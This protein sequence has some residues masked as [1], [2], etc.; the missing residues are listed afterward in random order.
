MIVSIDIETTGLNPE[1]HQILEIAAVAW[2]KPEVMDCP[3]FE[4]RVAHNEIVGDPAALAM[5]HRLLVEMDTAIALPFAIGRLNGWFLDLDE[6]FVR[7][8]EK[9]TLAGFNVGS[10]DLQF[11]KRTPGWDTMLFSH[12]CLEVGSLYA[13][14]YPRKSD[15]FVDMAE[16][17]GIPGRAHGALFDA[18]VALA[19]IVER[20]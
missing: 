6:K 14:P 5:N 2:T 1:K 10:F 16:S 19:A 3:A 18:R 11:L 20:F 17:H 8:D 4:I 13:D 15:H 9:I 7:Y 12:R